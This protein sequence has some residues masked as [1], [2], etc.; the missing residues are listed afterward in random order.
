V[1]SGTELTVVVTT[2]EGRE[3]LTGLRVIL[4]VDLPNGNRGSIAL[5]DDMVLP[6]GV[7]MAGSG[8]YTTSF[9]LSDITEGQILLTA[10]VTNPYGTARP[11][12]LMSRSGGWPPFGEPIEEFFQRLAQ[13]AI[14]VWVD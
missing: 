3:T 2:N 10:N 12:R 13:T 1:R 9:I 11:T 8:M 14:D 4:Y 5:S 6:D 7:R